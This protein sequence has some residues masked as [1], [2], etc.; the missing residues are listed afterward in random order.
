[1]LS[2]FFHSLRVDLGADVTLN[3][4]VK[5][6]VAPV[7]CSFK[8]FSCRRRN[9]PPA[10]QWALAGTRL[11]AIRAME[12]FVDE[13]LAPM[14]SASIAT[15]GLGPTIN[16]QQASV[17]LGCSEGHIEKLAESGRL[18]GTKYGRG[19]IFVTA[20]LLHHVVVECAGNLRAAE[21]SSSELAT[22]TSRVLVVLRQAPSPLT[23]EP[24][25]PPK[26]R[27]RPR[28]PLSDAPWFNQAVATATTS[29]AA[30][31]PRDSSPSKM[32]ASSE[33]RKLK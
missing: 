28:R 32:S 29:N 27:G 1:V 17:L 7:W 22:G 26:R 9:G 14:L 3:R 20:Q 8:D 23:L 16:A 2:R 31:E 4:F 12:T 25:A 15:S 6:G 30:P 13:S 21:A 18:P 33:P 10:L 19:W 11:L 24:I 5:R